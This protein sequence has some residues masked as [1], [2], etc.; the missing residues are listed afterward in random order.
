P[1]ALLGGA[2]SYSS[3]DYDGFRPNRGGEKPFVWLGPKPGVRV[4]YDVDA[5]Q[6]PRF[7]RLAEL[8]AASGQETHGVEVDY[9]IFENLQPPMPPDSSKPGK[10][11]EA[12]A[13]DFRLKDGSKAVDAGVGLPNVNDAFTGKAPDLGA[14]ELGQPLPVYGP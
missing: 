2:T 4:D 13:L 5:K 8:A 7:E 9:D 11:Y 3:Y 10:P 6:A 14:Y 12:I 1:I